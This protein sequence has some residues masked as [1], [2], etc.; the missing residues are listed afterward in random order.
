MVVNTAPQINTTDSL[1]QIGLEFLHGDTLTFV[2]EN[3]DLSDVNG[4]ILAEMTLSDKWLD[5]YIHEERG[6]LRFMAQ[7]TSFLMNKCQ[8]G[9]N[10]EATCGI[11]D[12]S[13]TIT[14]KNMYTYDRTI[15]LQSFELFTRANNSKSCRLDFI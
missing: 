9:S 6:E 14:L 7:G 8:I 3:C 5:D 13:I 15:F 2:F 4:N 1:K 10:F 12:G 11:E